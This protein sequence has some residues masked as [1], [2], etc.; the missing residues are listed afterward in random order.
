MRYAAD[1]VK[2]TVPGSAG[3]LGPGFDCLGMALGVVDT[4][5]VKLL[6]S[7]DI[8]VEVSGEGEGRI[9][10]DGTHLFVSTLRATL[11]RLDAPGTGLHVVARN[12]IPH[13]QGLGSSAATAVAAL[14]AARALIAEPDVLSDEDILTA[15]TLL[16]GHPDN[17]APALFGGAVVCWQDRAGAHATPLV[18]AEGVET[19]VVIPH[20][21]VPTVEA[22]AALPDSVPH[23]DA[24]FNASR[25][26][27]L[28]HALAGSPAL[29]FDATEDRLHQGYRAGHMPSAMAMMKELRERGLAAVVSGAGPAVLVLGTHL[30]GDG[31]ADGPLAWADGIGDDTWRCILTSESVPGATVERLG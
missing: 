9:P 10:L 24:A 5:E 15:A 4:I 12:S 7:T 31:F 30:A 18:V 26:A 3:N 13:G 22:R 25:A 14:V 19:A 28:V 23:K 1:H 8:I 6:A 2:V 27:L 20:G 17:A 21:V 11:N 29:L 16:E